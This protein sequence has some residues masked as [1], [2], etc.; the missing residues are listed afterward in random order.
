[1]AQCRFKEWGGYW[2]SIGGDWKRKM[3]MKNVER[4]RERVNGLQLRIQRQNNA[5]ETIVY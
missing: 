2:D 3:K 4:E 5:K 1:M